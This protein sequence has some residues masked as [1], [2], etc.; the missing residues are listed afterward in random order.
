MFASSL[1]ESANMSSREPSVKISIDSQM[2]SIR[3]LSCNSFSGRSP[4]AM[5]LSTRLKEASNLT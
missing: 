4:I 2:P 3:M 5:G 1:A